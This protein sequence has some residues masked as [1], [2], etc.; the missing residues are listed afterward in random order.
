MKRI[1]VYEYDKLT[2]SHKYMDQGKLDALLKFNEY[3]DY[4]FFNGKLFP[5]CKTI[6]GIILTTM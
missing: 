5:K 3:H 1:V 6:H 4:K 2:L